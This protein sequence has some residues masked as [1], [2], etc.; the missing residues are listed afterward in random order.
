MDVREARQVLR[1]AIVP[2]MT[3]YNEDQ[4]LDVDGLTKLVDEMVQRGLV[5]GSGAILAAGAGGDFPVLSMA[6]RKAV[7]KAVV[8]A[9]DGRVPVLFSNQHCSTAGAIEL[10][11]YAHS[12][13]VTA[14]Q[15]GTP[16]YYDV[17]TDDEKFAFIKAV[18]DAVDIPLMIYNTWWIGEQGRVSLDLVGR[19]A[20]LEHVVAIKWSAP[21]QFEFTEGLLLY[22]DKL[23]MINNGVLPVYAHKLGAT[24]FITSMGNFWPEHEVRLF[25][26]MEEKDYDE[27]ERLWFSVNWPWMRVLI[28]SWS[29]MT[30]E[31]PATKAALDL[32]GMDGG[33]PRS[34]MRSLTV[35]EREQIREVL[36][37]I[38]CP[39]RQ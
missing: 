11:E 39:R 17:L 35:D 28:R 37:R 22:A 29:R 36:D 20:D 3:L 25:Q 21:D 7:A 9:A 8:E 12:I 18:N 33:A 2:V 26:A 23:A 30:G 15:A 34:P 31:S 16:Y 5:T 38:G 27:A 13:G 32:C 1:G 4:S 24:G 6:E 10:A 14:L 19:L